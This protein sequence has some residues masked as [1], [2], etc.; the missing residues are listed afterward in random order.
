MFFG[1]YRVLCSCRDIECHLVTPSEAQ[2]LCPLL[3]VDDLIGGIWIPGDGVT[4][5][6]QTC[7]TLIDEARKKGIINC[8]LK[9]TYLRL[10]KISIINDICCICCRSTNI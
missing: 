4:D 3:R 2:E 8:V 7:L 5:P 9:I 6:Y 10:Y 1:N